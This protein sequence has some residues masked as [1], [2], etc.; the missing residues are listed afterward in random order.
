MVVE[1]DGGPSRACTLVVDGACS[2]HWRTDHPASA[3]VRIIVPEPVPGLVRAGKATGTSVVMSG[4]V[5]IEGDR[6]GLA[7]LTRAVGGPGF[8]PCLART[9][10]PPAAEG[11]V[12]AGRIPAVVVVLAA[13]ND[14][15]GG[16]SVMAKDRTRTAVD[17]ARRTSGARIVL[18]GGFG[19][20][21]N[22]TREPHWKHCLRWLEPQGVLLSDILACL[23]TR[24]TYDDLLFLRELRDYHD[25]A[26]AYL[27]TSAYHADRVRYIAKLVLPE[28][29][30]VAVQHSELPAERQKTF[31]DHESEALARTVA[32]TLLFGPDFL[33]TPLERRP[34]H[35]NDPD[36]LRPPPL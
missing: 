8:R 7:A 12:A 4:C 32:A 27:I 14:D 20:Q 23:E 3:D 35:A 28:C 13:P 6:R 10:S 15:R 9:M 21:F 29:R 36:V 25:F 2:A 26:D 22:T 5:A 19:R 1:R 31:S 24:H 33:P 34:G 11:A 18:T 16:L 30:V 17:V